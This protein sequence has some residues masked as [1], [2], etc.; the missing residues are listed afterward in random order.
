MNDDMVSDELKGQG[1]QT[2]IES[3]DAQRRQADDDP[4]QPGHGA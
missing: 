2:E 4:D 3:L 1:R